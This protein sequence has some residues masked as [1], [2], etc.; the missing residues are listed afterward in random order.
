MMDPT[1]LNITSMGT[2]EVEEKNAGKLSKR[3]GTNQPLKVRGISEKPTQVYANH[4]HSGK[5]FLNYH[6]NLKIHEESIIFILL[7]K[8]NQIKSFFKASRANK[9][10]AVGGRNFRKRTLSLT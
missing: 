5:F 7:F 8:I 6:C 10:A 1:L 4:C 2:S 9:K 3:F